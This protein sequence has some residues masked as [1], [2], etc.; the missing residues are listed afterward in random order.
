MT[1][2]QYAFHY[3]GQGIA[4]RSAVMELLCILGRRNS[5]PFVRT[6]YFHGRPLC[7]TVSWLRTSPA[8][9][10]VPG[11]VQVLSAGFLSSPDCKPEPQGIW[12]SLIP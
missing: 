8:P 1:S 6:G 10:L 3:L 7:Y 2:A 11:M 9:G 5:A 12:R 4:L